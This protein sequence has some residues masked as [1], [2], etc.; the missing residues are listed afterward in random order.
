[1]LADC[2]SFYASVEKSEH[3]EF[4]DRPLVVAGDPKRRSGII[5][6]ACPIAK[7][8]GITT[9]ERLGDSL[10]KC[11]D[12]VIMQPRMQLYIDISLMITGIYQSFTDLVEP[13]SIDEQF[14]DVTGSLHLYGT[15][16]ELASLIQKRVKAETGIHTRF[17]IGPSKVL[18]KTACDNYAKKNDSGVYVLSKQ[19]LSTTL[20]TL[21]I[22]KMFM[23][24]SRMTRHFNAM[25]LETIGQLAAT[26]LEK[27]KTMMHRKLG[28]NSDINA[29]L[30]WRI[31]NGI[32]NS[33]VTPGTHGT[34]PQ[35]IGHMMTLPRDYAM[36]EEI[37]IVLLELTELVCQRC[38]SKGYMGHVVSVACMGA[39]YDR[40]SGFSRQMKMEDPTNV[41]NQVFRFVMQLLRQHW[42]GL[43]VRKVGVSLSEFNPDD[44]Y[45]LSM[46]NPD[47]EKWMALERA[48]DAIKQKYGD[49]SIL[50]AV[51][52]TPIGQAT[53]RAKKIGGHYK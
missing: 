50:R 51:S 34:A 8:F 14:L 11:P 52:A 28:R 33:P 6:A 25:G 49:S 35:T 40:P 41:T 21:P 39:D 30:Y 5:L 36:L 7:S 18:A 23:V 26:P 2:Q 31:A 16:E 42:D 43:P 37:K 15:P 27:L 10:S 17:G 20:W 48:T 32:D 22:A 13:Y 45:Q 47:Q 12:L 29:E 38:R 19:N 1:M 46:F 24:G 53:D 4:R 44:E 3:P 9:A